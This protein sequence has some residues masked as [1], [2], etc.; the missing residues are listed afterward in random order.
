MIDLSKLSIRSAH[1]SMVKKV[2]SAVELSS[3][4][5][6][7]IQRKNPT[8]HAYLE[9]FS[10]V[11]AQAKN[12]QE[13]IEKNGGTLLT[14]IPFAIKDNI[15]I[16]DH[17]ASASSKILANFVSPYDSTVASKLKNEGVV[18]LGRTNMDE[19]AM[20]SSTE[21]SA[22]GVTRNPHDSS[23]VPGGSSG[24]STAS[25]AMDGAMVALGSDTG[26]SVR[27]PASFCG[28]VGLKPTYGSVSRHGLIALGSSLDQIGPI[29]KSVD[30]V[31]IIFKAIVG[32]DPLDST[33][34][35]PEKVENVPN[36]IRIGVPRHLL[37]IEGLSQKVKENFEESIV[38]LQKLGFEIVDIK[39]PN[40]NYALAVYY[41][42]MP[43]EASS[44]LARLDGVKYGLHVDGKDLLEDYLITRREGFGRET[45]RRIMLGTYVLSSGYYD[46]YYSKAN[47]MREVIRNDY[48]EAF[49]S[50]DIIVTPTTPTSAFKIGEKA[51]N[52]LEMYLA[53]IFTVPANI[54]GNP[55]I[56]V[57]SGFEDSMGFKLPLGIQFV[58]PH[59]HEDILFKVGKK[60]LGEE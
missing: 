38:K 7:V 2:F 50:V 48:D 26:G 18:F 57:P 23:R 16:K 22:N 8:I 28:C 13:K 35:Y 1:E 30:D 21:N 11:E 5:L 29:G 9:I 55:A 59:F 6:D 31:E 41:I 4:Y 24:G 10:D 51:N 15:L 37:E 32:R 53:D 20:G 58:A 14:G 45:R 27:Q 46:A 56:S 33:S 39:L 43:A 19:F 52:P 36:K 49:K 17:I 42:L 44:N 60:F 34:F 54:A 25:V 3:A 47:A 12:A 40:A